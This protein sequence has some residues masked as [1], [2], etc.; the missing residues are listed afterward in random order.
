MILLMCCH[1]SLSAQLNP[2]SQYMVVKER[3]IPY[4]EDF[5]KYL[6]EEKWSRNYFGNKYPIT[7]LPGAIIFKGEK[8]IIFEKRA[9]CFDFDNINIRARKFNNPEHRY[10]YKNSC[11]DLALE[12][13][14]RY[15]DY[16]SLVA[17][18][19]RIAQIRVYLADGEAGEY[20]YTLFEY[21]IRRSAARSQ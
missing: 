8:Y 19:W 6:Q 20:D 5:Q 21:K 7:F 16:P 4:D 18:E 1:I 15:I 10:R 13:T 14:S 11:E 17:G 3:K 12:I 9:P 2:A